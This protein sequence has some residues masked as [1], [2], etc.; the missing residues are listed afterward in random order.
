[1]PEDS[2]RSALREALSELRRENGASSPYLIKLLDVSSMQAVNA[3]IANILDSMEQDETIQAL[4][5]AFGIGNLPR[6]LTLR[7]RF[8]ARNLSISVAELSRREDVALDRLVDGLLRVIRFRIIS[9]SEGTVSA[10]MDGIFT[11]L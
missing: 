11:S 9:Q 3:A 5:N 7:R 6:E 10:V 2:Q 4:R 8:L 1:M